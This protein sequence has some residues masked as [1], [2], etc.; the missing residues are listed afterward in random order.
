METTSGR[1]ADGS[2][3]VCSP[4]PAGMA[5]SMTGPERRV[6]VVL[7][8]RN[9]CARTLDSLEKLLAL[10]ERPAV[11]VVDNASTDATAD[12]IV[13]RHPG[14]T[15]LRLPANVGAAG[16]NCGVAVTDAPYVAFNDDDSWWAAGSLRRAADILDANPATGLL[17]ARVLVGD[18][19][20]LDPS[21]QAMEASPL[22]STGGPG[23]EV[24]GFVA[25][26]AVVRREAFL[27]VGGFSPRYG[28]GG[29]E[30]LLALDLAAAGWGLSYCDDLVAHHHPST[31]RPPPAERR[32]HQARNGLRT[33]WLRRRP[34]GAVRRSLEIARGARS[35][36]AVRGA[37]VDLLSDLGWIARDRRPVPRRLEQHARLLS[38]AGTR[39]A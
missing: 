5:T 27:A 37:F 23:R 35:D 30:E 33:A 7:L 31:L 34:G 17:A 21:C 20:R 11:T 9:R 6:G 10:P 32:R 39:P 28:I 14:V 24:L 26:G 1:S 4:A 18:D 12:E 3:G 13:R 36:A 8:T 19:A 25:C 15:V 38:E 16:R 29:E 22:P 2:T